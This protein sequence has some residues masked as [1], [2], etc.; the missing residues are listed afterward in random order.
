VRDVDFAPD[1]S[2]F[3]VVT[4]GGS[5][6]GNDQSVGCDS[7]ARFRATSTGSRI[8]PTWITFTGNDSLTAVAATGAVVYTGGHNRWINNP[9]GSDNAGPGAVERHGLAALDP[10]TGNALSWNPGRTLGVGV[11]D[12]VPTTAGLWIGHDTDTVANEN[13]GKLAFFPL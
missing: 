10:A 13:H 8:E 1:G 12:M 6:S 9:Y 3:A 4:S 2:Y 5:Y 11:F 7:A